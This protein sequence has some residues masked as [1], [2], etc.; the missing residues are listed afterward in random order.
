MPNGAIRRFV[1]GTLG[2]RC[3]D[4]VFEH[5]E[6]GFEDWHGARCLRM[7]IGGRLLIRIVAAPDQDKLASQLARWMDAGRE[8]RDALGLNRFRLVLKARSPAQVRIAVEGV[9]T[10]V[11][12]DEHS[13]VHVVTPDELVRVYPE[14]SRVRR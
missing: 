8:E 2:C 13:H 5:I 10:E 1:Q 6:S 14:R 11:G 7:L 9:L 12:S 4:R 3:A